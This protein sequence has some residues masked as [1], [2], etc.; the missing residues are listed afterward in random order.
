MAAALSREL[1]V[2][3]A[4]F[5]RRLPDAVEGRPMREVD[6]AIVVDATNNGRVRIELTQKG[7]AVQRD[8]DQRLL[9]VDFTFE[10]MT[11][12]EAR[13]FMQA[14]DSRMSNIGGP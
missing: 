7:G 1:H 2:A 9:H 6:G 8:H 10:S 13:M 5:M 12:D 11:D 3:K 4:E 14:Y